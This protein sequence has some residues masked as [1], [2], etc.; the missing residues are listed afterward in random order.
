MNR[1]N[2]FTIYLSYI[3]WSD[4]NS[5]LVIKE[6]LLDQLLQIEQVRAI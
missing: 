6:R 1:V 2:N 4:G 3:D 5:L